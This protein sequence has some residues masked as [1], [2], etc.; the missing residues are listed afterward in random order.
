MLANLNVLLCQINEDECPHDVVILLKALAI[1][2]KHFFQISVSAVVV[3]LFQIC[4]SDTSKPVRLS[5]WQF[6]YLCV[7]SSVV[8]VSVRL[9][10]VI[11]TLGDV[12][13]ASRRM[14]GTTICA[15]YKYS[16]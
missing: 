14:L 10:V 13:Y 8:L 1:Q 5:G 15:L 3:C 9:T 2:D 4:P 7:G 12:V 16:F 6:V 11:T